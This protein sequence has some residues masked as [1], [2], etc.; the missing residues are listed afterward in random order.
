MII[1]DIGKKFRSYSAKQL[2]LGK[3]FFEN[4][5]GLQDIKNYLRFER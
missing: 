2:V 4:K 3:V 1:C 5:N